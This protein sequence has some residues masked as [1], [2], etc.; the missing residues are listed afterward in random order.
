[1]RHATIHRQTRETNVRLSLNLDGRGKFDIQTNIGFF[2][3]MLETF[4]KH[5]LFDL[6]IE[7]EGDLYVDEHHL[8]ED[9]GIALGQAFDKALGKRQGIYRFGFYHGYFATPLDEALALVAVDLGGRSALVFKA[10]FVNKKI[11]SLP[12]ELLEDFFKAF[13]NDARATVHINLL[14]GRNDHHR[15]EAIFKA[16]AKALRMAVEKDQRNK[17][18]V[19]STK[20]VI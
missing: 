11:G 13:A 5:G 16:F 7:A 3:H 8:V 2:N 20:G 17:N 4:A 10:K 19:P 15:A 12:T 1:M 18:V 14:E 6:K 9:I